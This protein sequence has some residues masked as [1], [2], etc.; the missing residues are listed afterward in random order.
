MDRSS[1]KAGRVLRTTGAVAGD[2]FAE[3]DANVSGTSARVAEDDC[4]APSVVEA[5]PLTV[6]AREYFFEDV[7]T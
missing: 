3:R 4:V 6:P 2:P 5:D 1:V 7:A